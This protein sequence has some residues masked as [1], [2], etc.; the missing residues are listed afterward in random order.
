MKPLSTVIFFTL[1]A[2]VLVSVPGNIRAQQ[3]SET[4]Q[5]LGE[6]LLDAVDSNDVEALRS[7]LSIA[8]GRTLVALPIGLTAA[9]RAVERGYYEVA[10]HILAV[11]AQQIQL[12][13]EEGAENTFSKPAA[14]AEGPS[15]SASPAKQLGQTSA[16]ARL[17][18]QILG[19]LGVIAPKPAEKPTPKVSNQTEAPT[20]EPPPPSRNPF[21][22]SRTPELELPPVLPFGQA[23][24]RSDQVNTFPAARVAEPPNLPLRAP[25][26]TYG[27]RY[28]T[29]N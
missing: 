22:S 8:S 11:R 16:R 27:D 24:G 25:S 2:A 6:R 18:R 12:E 21:E 14:Q 28:S 3:N 13:N 29:C 7:I 5:Q 23:S 10:H 1:L 17:G 20:S 19:P 4:T 26:E 15:Q 9:G